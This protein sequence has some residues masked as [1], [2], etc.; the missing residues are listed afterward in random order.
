MDV[1]DKPKFI[2]DIIGEVKHLSDVIEHECTHT[3]CDKCELQYKSKSCRYR[4]N[5]LA[6]LLGYQQG[7]CDEYAKHRINDF[8]Y[9]EFPHLMQK[10]ERH[11]NTA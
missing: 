7:S 5:L 2:D 1:K 8:L 11:G 6:L 3:S 4:S 9:Q 10:L